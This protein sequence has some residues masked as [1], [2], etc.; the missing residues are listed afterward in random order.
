MTVL[1]R[2]ILRDTV[3]LILEGKLL[4]PTG[5][6]MWDMKGCPLVMGYGL[7]HMLIGL[8]SVECVHSFCSM[9]EHMFCGKAL[10]PSTLLC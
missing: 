8:G 3:K 7:E 9:V 10:P 2:S 4:S 5:A 6:W 1:R